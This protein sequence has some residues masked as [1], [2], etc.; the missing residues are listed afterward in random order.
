MNGIAQAGRQSMQAETRILLIED[1]ATDAEIEIWELKRAGMRVAY[2]CVDTEDAFRR[3]LAEFRPQVILSDFSMPHFDGMWALSLARELAPEVPFIFVSGT[4]GEEYAV[5]ALKNGAVDYVL[6]GN[7]A[8]LPVAVERALQEKDER[9][10]RREAESALRDA[11]E[12]H[13]ATFEHVPVGIMHA[14]ADSGRILLAN[15]RLVA[16]LGYSE[17]ELAGM[18]ADD[19]VHPDHRDADRADYREGM[20]E[21]ELTSFSSERVM[22]RKDASSLWVERTVSLVRDGAGKPLYFIH[23]IQDITK[24]KH[25]QRKIARLSRIHAVLSGINSAIVRIRDRDVL[26][27]EACRI[28]VEQGEYG[29]AW[30]GLF[31]PQTLD[32]TPVAWA[33]IGSD[34]L[35]QV[36]ATARADMPLGEGVTGRAIRER[37]PVYENDLSVEPQKGRLWVEALR[38]GYGSVIALPLIVENAVAAV[39][40]LYAKGANVFT[41]QERKLLTELAANI[42]FALEHIGKAQKIEYLAYNSEQTGLPN[43]T[44]FRDRLQQRIANAQGDRRKSFSVMMLDIERFRHINDSLGRPAGD[45]LLRQL[46]E[47]LKGSIEDTDALAHLGGDYFAIATRRAEGG[48]GVAQ[49]LEQILTGISEQAFPVGGE[50]LRISPRA[51]IA[52]Y[53]ADGAEADGLLKN[54]EAA[55]KE[56]KRMGH[57]Y[58]FYAPQMNARVAEQLKLENELRRA[59]LEE[60]FVLH[61]QPRVELAG[62]RVCGLEALIRWAHP[63]RGLVPP[64]EFIPLLETTGMI[65]DVGRWALKQATLDHAAWRAAGLKP[66]RIAVNVSVIQLR[67]EQFVEDVRAAVSEASDIREYLDIEIT[68]SMLMEDV[69]GNIGKLAAVQAMG[70][71]IAMDDFGTGYSSLSYLAKLPINSLK[72]DR[73]FVSQMVSGPVQ[74]AIISTVISLARAL[75]L[76]VVAEGVE[77]KDQANLLRLLGCDEAQGYLFCKPLPPE[78]YKRLFVDSNSEQL[79]Q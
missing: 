6:K 46:A 44:L 72:I 67:R 28:A 25:Q 60:Q 57:R 59:I 7:L 73:S 27:H 38:H 22:L 61:Y 17:D 63:E 12:R 9:A 56:A 23:M 10:T 69:D 36:N 42:S 30:I 13:R 79:L 76:K 70:M 65:L 29:L 40:G 49:L 64:A 34:D 3:A 52:L 75:N 68:E 48:E 71:Q 1:Q 50:D 74:M 53:P 5:R 54:A 47:R 78:E 14:D 35:K 8:R 45:D 41:D 37:K 21:S 19:S 33:G 32:V 18:T 31:D 51:G 58:Q 26:F 20:L 11:N 66:P 24:R 2:R 39:L 55:L 62:G 77:T 15:P 4:M 16:L 43:R